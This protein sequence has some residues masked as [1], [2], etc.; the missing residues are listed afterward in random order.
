M[1]VCLEHGI[2]YRE[3]QTC[4]KCGIRQWNEARQKN[5]DEKH[6]VKKFEKSKPNNLKKLR[7]R[8]QNLLSS[9]FKKKYCKGKYENCWICHKPVLVKGSHIMNTVHCSHFYPKSIYWNLA[10]NEENL[11]CCCY[12]CN[13]NNPGTVPALRNKLVS[14]HGEQKIKELD[15]LA[16]QFMIKVNTK[17]LKSRPDELYLLAIINELKQRK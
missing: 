7:D 16:E 1:P 6:T 13:V 8:A 12:N 9:W 17:Q 4:S 11:S 3:N 15:N 10:Y 14:I 2:Y 5:K